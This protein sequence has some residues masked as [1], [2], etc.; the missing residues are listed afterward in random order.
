M[1]N[2][3][4]PPAVKPP[5]TP[6]RTPLMKRSGARVGAVIAAAAAIAFVV[7]LLVGGSSNSSS[8]NA[9]STPAGA[10]PVKISLGGLTTLGAALS[11]PIY[12]AG[13]QSGKQ[14]ELTKASDGR[15]WIRYLP[16][17]ADIGE[18]D[19]PYLTVGTYPVRRA[20]AATQTA[21]ASG[22]AVKIAVGS[23]AVAFYNTAHPTSV[24]LAYKG[25]DYQV[26]V[27]DPSS[28]AAQQLVS[29]GKITLIPGSSAASTQAGSGG[30]VALNEPQLKRRAKTAALPI[31]WF[32]PKSSTTYELTQLQDGRTYVRYLPLGTQAGS[33]TPFLTIGTYPLANAYAV[34][35][36]AAHG[37]GSVE[38]TVPGGVGF[39]S[40]TSPKNVHVAYPNQDVQIEV[41][42]PSANQAHRLV[43][44]GTLAPIS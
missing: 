1:T 19:T 42:D 25:S 11:Q 29:S 33:N 23:N 28:T 17:D 44:S 41:F 27:F 5:S 32:G 43:S 31:Y 38:I 24:Y 35:Q 40:Q 9:P 39:Y 14:Y 10:K 2:T 13:A 26:E 16:A 3:V 6:S 20:Y 34:T 37:S 21:A 8:T 12:W 36:S 18:R 7:W 4:E 15:V 22:N 30:A